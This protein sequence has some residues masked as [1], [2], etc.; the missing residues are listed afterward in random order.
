MHALTD[1]HTTDNS[2]PPKRLGETLQTMGFG[3]QSLPSIKWEAWTR[4]GVAN[5]WHESALSMADIANQ[6]QCSF[7]WDLDAASESFSTRGFRQP[8]LIN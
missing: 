3:T 1:R 2:Q 4:T 5:T 7:P 6:L 8:L